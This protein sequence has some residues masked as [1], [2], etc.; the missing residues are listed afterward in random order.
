MIQEAADWNFVMQWLVNSNSL[1]WFRK[2]RWRNADMI[3]VFVAKRH[4]KSEALEIDDRQAEAAEGD[5]AQHDEGVGHG[6]DEDDIEQFHIAQRI[7][8]VGVAGAGPA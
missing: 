6:I 2:L 4:L 5:P 3:K 1:P 7:Y 8:G